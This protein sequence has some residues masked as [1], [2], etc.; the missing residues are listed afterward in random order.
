MSDRMIPMSFGKMMH[1]ILTEYETQGRIFGVSKYHHAKPATLSIFGETVENPMGPAAGPHTQLAQNIV[2]AY[3]SGARFF[4]LKT[5][6]KLDGEDLPVNKPCI[7]APDEAYN[8]EWSTELHVPEALEEYV[9]AWV[10]LKVLSREFGFGSDTG[11]IFNMS[12]GYDLEGIQS[13]KIDNFIES[14]KDATTT[15]CFNECKTWLLAN[16]NRFQHINADFVQGISPQVCRSITL[17]TL[18]GCPPA[19]IERI[20]SYL[21]TKKKLHTYIKCNPTLLG[22]ETA[23]GLLNQLG[24][25]HVPFDSHHFDNDLQFAD[26]V[27]MLKRLQSLADEHELTFGVKITNTFPVQITENEL[28]GTE[29]YMSGRALLPLSL[30]VAQKLATAFDGHLQVSYSGGADALNIADIFQAGIWPITL[31]TTLLKSGGYERL[32]QIADT[33]EAKTACN[34]ISLDRLN[35]LCESILQDT[36]NHRSPKA[37]PRRKLAAHVPLVDC[38]VAPCAHTCP[39]GQDIP[40]YVSLV[41]QQRYVEALDVITQQNPLPF[42]TGSICA[43]SCMAACTRHDYDTPVN[44]RNLKLVAAQQGMATLLAQKTLIP[45]HK[46]KRVAIVGAGPAGLATAVYLRRQGFDVTTFD[47]HDTAGGVVRHIIPSFRIDAAVIE[48]DILWVAAHGVTFQLGKTVTPQDLQGFDITVLAIGAWKAGTLKLAGTTPLGCFAFLSDFATKR[49]T[50]SLGRHVAIIGAGN[51]AMDAARAAKRVTGVETVT[52][53]YRRTKTQM[54]ADAEELELAV[55]EGITLC[56]L[57][58]P[59]SH[60]DGQLTCAVCELGAPDASGRRRPVETSAH[61]VYEIDTVIAAVGEKVD[62]AVLSAFGVTMDETS[63]P[64]VNPETLETATSNVYLAGDA[65]RGPATIVEAMADGLKIAHAVS[66]S[67]DSPSKIMSGVPADEILTRKATLMPE[68]HDDTEASRCLSC[69][70][71]CQHCCEVCPNRAN[72]AVDTSSGVQILHIDALCNECGN[73]RQF[74]PYNSAPYLHKFTYFGSEAFMNDNTNDGF[75]L[76]DTGDCVVRIQN[77]LHL[78]ETDKIPNI[79]PKLVALIDS[80]RSNYAY[81]Q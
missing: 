65:Y 73:C 20:A 71:I 72:I 2:T 32:A 74:C 62:T 28:P 70:E 35:A 63:R 7:I 69:H 13:P 15:A 6:Q 58:A 25:T 36:R 33:L 60:I 59:I 24:F 50:L 79:E 14:L 38:Y 43:H 52:V 16:L 75:L 19:E 44:I 31:A 23:R 57:R 39:I 21:I 64:I 81:I 51:S 48:Q 1:W 41:G 27:P 5:V 55:A 4:E 80:F 29:K 30:H 67:V 66:L 40:R 56:E 12:V 47:A 45:I 78:Y 37:A 11:F 53:F 22:Y 77:K 26:A 10:A 49:D 9:K 34:G 54:P 61:E 42:I 76:Q 8:V 3:V 68:C 18:H 46:N 17:S